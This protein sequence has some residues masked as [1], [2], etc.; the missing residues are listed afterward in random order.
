MN[1]VQKEISDSI[2]GL[3]AESKSKLNVKISFTKEFIGFNGHFDEQP[4]LPAI[5]FFEIIKCS[6]YKQLNTMPVV[7]DVLSAKFYNV[8]TVK[9][10]VDISILSQQDFLDKKNRDNEFILNAKFMGAGSK[11][12]IIKIKVRI[13]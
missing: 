10:I 1:L 5:C 3:K 2:I 6:L 4:V 11:K 13:G 12:A 7:C 9:E 8:I